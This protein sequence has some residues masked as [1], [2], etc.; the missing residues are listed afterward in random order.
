MIM[1][2]TGRNERMNFQAKKMSPYSILIYL[3][4]M[5][6]VIGTILLTLPVSSIGEGRI[7]VIDSL[8]FHSV[9]IRTAGFQTLELSG[10]KTTTL[11]VYI[12]LMFIGASSGS[13]GAG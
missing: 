2:I 5:V 4:F 1:E 11:L 8:F 9:S 12:I 3:Y 10:M 6:I 13:I 7:P